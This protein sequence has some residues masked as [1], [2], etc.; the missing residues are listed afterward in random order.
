MNMNRIC[1]DWGVDGTFWSIISV[2]VPHLNE[3]KIK[4]QLVFTCYTPFKALVLARAQT[5]EW[6]LSL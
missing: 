6:L 5:D 2:Y 1:M 3:I 4:N